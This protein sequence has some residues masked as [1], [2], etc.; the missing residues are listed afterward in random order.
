MCATTWFLIQQP[1]LLKKNLFK[2]RVYTLGVVEI[3][4]L[5]HIYTSPVIQCK[6]F[7]V[8]GRKMLDLYIYVIGR[9]N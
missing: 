4:F 8:F 5:R 3:N 6:L 1:A 7:R 9:T 2:G